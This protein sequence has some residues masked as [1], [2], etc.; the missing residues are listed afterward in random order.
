[1]GALAAFGEGVI[2]SGSPL[3]SRI[4]QA[5]LV[6][7]ARCQPNQTPWCGCEDLQQDE[8]GSRISKWIPWTASFN[9]TCV[10]GTQEV[11]Y[12]EAL[13]GGSAFTCGLFTMQ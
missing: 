3:S 7:A 8:T 11:G 6:P 10:T 12:E 2:L 9:Q 13:L 1:L 4:I 5:A